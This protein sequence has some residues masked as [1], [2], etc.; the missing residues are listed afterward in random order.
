MALTEQQKSSV[1]GFE[2]EGFIEYLSRA[3]AQEREQAFKEVRVAYGEELMQYSPDE[4]AGHEVKVMLRILETLQTI[5]TND[6]P[7]AW[8]LVQNVNNFY[9]DLRKEAP[10]EE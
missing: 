6:W 4:P 9:D 1:L 3:T 10:Q 7:E 5:Q 2:E 8:Q